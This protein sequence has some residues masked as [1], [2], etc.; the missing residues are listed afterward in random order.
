MKSTGEDAASQRYSIEKGCLSK[1]A[2]FFFY[3]ELTETFCQ[4]DKSIND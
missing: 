3:V 1:R 4:Q 2:T